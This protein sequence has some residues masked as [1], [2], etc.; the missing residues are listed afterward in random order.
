MD[1]QVRKGG[2]VSDLI[3]KANLIQKKK[4]YKKFCTKTAPKQLIAKMTNRKL[5]IYVLCRRC[6]YIQVEITMS[7][8]LRTGNWCYDSCGM[9]PCRKLGRRLLNIKTYYSMIYGSLKRDLLRKNNW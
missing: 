6:H 4:K 5:H 7:Q 2:I 1:F 9:K 3:K 8:A